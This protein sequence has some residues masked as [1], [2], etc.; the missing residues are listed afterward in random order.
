[1]IRSNVQQLRSNICKRCAKQR[2]LII[3]RMQIDVPYLSIPMGE[4]L[5]MRL[6]YCMPDSVTY[7]YA[8]CTD[9][10]AYFLV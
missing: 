5:H 6:V 9:N 1:M 4:R 7:V 2:R 10:R 3:R 8:D